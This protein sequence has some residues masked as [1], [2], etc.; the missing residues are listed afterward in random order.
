[1]FSRACDQTESKTRWPS[2]ASAGG[3]AGTARIAPRSAARRQRDGRRASMPL[4]SRG[5]VRHVEPADA[6]VSRPRRARAPS[7]PLL[8]RGEG[9]P[10]VVARA[11]PLD[12]VDA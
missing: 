5:A 12:V 10:Q 8:R 6:V 3:A 2:K 4:V 9:Q 1:M 11:M 7:E